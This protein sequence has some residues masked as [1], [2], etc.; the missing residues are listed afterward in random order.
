MR[1]IESGSRAS[2]KPGT[3]GGGYRIVVLAALCFGDAMMLAAQSRN[4][5]PQAD[6]TVHRTLCE[7]TAWEDPVRLT[8]DPGVV[9]IRYPEVAAAAERIVIVGQDV[10]SNDNRPI[11][12]DLLRIISIDGSDLGRPAGEWYGMFPRAAFSNEGELHL[13]WGEPADGAV[14]DLLWRLQDDDDL[15][16][17]PRMNIGALRS[18]ALFHAR[19]TEESG[20][21]EPEEIVR[22]PLPL[23]WHRDGGG[24]VADADG[25]VHLIVGETARLMHFMWDSNHGW[26]GGALRHAMGGVYSS[27]TYTPSDGIVATYAGAGNQ[28]F[29]LRLDGDVWSAP[30]RL[31]SSYES[32]ASSMRVFST[33][34]NTVVVAW[35]AAVAEPELE[36]Q[37]EFV[38]SLD[39]G[40]SWSSRAAVD[41]P[42]AAQQ[43]RFAADACGTIHVLYTILDET[44]EPGRVVGQHWVWHGRWNGTWHQPK[45]IL[46]EYN[47]I[48]STLAEDRRG[49]VLLV[50]AFRPSKE[51]GFHPA[52]RTMTARLRT[53]P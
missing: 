6:D 23:A 22:T 46:T 38:T 19:Y 13:V 31:S 7:P 15:L 27:I 18:V 39:S 14:E 29:A 52:F 50:G 47:V 36:M 43:V 48:Y 2:S 40:R 44:A 33:D 51:T 41:V 12:P 17:H 28:V 5:A 32:I 24:I 3:A 16:R 11:T 1:T 4:P 30:V 37:I 35:L 8:D 34:A 10:R 25:R 53:K 42:I 26:R 20:W 21:S 9:S 45:N 49:Q